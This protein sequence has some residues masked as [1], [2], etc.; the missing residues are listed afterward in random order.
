MYHKCTGLRIFYVFNLQ[1]KSGTVSSG[2]V[3][4]WRLKGGVSCYRLTINSA[5]Y[6]STRSFRESPVPRAPRSYWVVH[7]VRVVN[8]FVFSLDRVSNDPAW[9]NVINGGT[10]WLRY[11]SP[12]LFSLRSADWVLIDD[13]WLRLP[14]PSGLAL[15]A[16]DFVLY[17]WFD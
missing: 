13:L 17:W 3:Q 9:A 1:T 15:Y 4:I 12:S 2:M 14:S 8:M 6:W 10:S 16:S 7:V 11:T 5:G